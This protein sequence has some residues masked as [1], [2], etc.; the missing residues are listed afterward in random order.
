MQLACEMVVL[1]KSRKE[2]MP[3]YTP[4]SIRKDTK[5]LHHI[6]HIP[7]QNGMACH[8]NGFS[9]RGLKGA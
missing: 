9:H 6:I 3:P 1:L 8:F 4:C 7:L 2:E 5:E